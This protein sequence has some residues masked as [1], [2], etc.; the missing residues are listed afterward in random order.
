MTATIYRPSFAVPPQRA[1]PLDPM[2]PLF[3]LG[4]VC[5]TPAA[6]AAI[7][8]ANQTP[9]DF[10]ARHVG[11]DWIEMDPED[12]SANTDALREG[13]RIFS[14]YTIHGG[15]KLYVI[16]E[17]DRSRTTLCF[18]MSIDMA[19]FDEADCDRID[20]LRDA[21]LAAIRE[22]TRRT[23]DFYRA[24][25]DFVGPLMPIALTWQRCSDTH[26]QL[27]AD[28]FATTATTTS[29]P[30]QRLATTDRATQ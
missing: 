8:Q 28:Y 5:G 6:L 25:L 13:G 4:A 14:A 15:A 9:T 30:S 2:A 19:R 29:P 1:N 26:R 24:G 21:V 7:A 3:E 16:T 11:A 22:R 18:P 20:A 10:L 17:A 12:I 27:V 23:T